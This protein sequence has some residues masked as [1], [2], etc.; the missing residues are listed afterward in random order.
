MAED[1][2]APMLAMLELMRNL[3]ATVV[4]L[5]D[6]VDDLAEQLERVQTGNARPW[7]AAARMH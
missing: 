1:P 6:R 2:E 3:T 7:S 4:A 5:R